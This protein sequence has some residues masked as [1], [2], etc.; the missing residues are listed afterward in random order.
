MK[1]GAGAVLIPF[2]LFCQCAFPAVQASSVSVASQYFFE[3]GLY[4]GQQRSGES[5]ALTPSFSRSWEE[6]R[7]TFDV[8]LFYRWDSVD[9]ERTHFDLRELSY[10]KA[11]E[12]WELR[13]GVC[14]VFWGATESRHLVDVIN[15]TDWVENIRGEDKLGQPMI[16]AA[17]VADAGT[18]DIFYLPYFR[19]RTFPGQQGRFRPSV[20]V[21]ESLV[22]YESSREERH[23]DW[24]LRWSG[25]APFDYGISFFDGTN[26]EPEL[27]PGLDRAGSGVLFPHY[28]QMKQLSMD[29]Q[30]A[31]NSWLWKFEGL[32]RHAS[33]ETFSAAVGGVEYTIGTSLGTDWGLLFEYGQDD[34]IGA[35]YWLKEYF[36][37]G[38]RM[39][40]N[41]FD[42]TE[43][44]VG[45][46]E[47]R[48][49]GGGL[50]SVEAKRT[51]AGN[52]KANFEI[53]D[54]SDVDPASPFY[55]FRNDSYAE[56]RLEYFF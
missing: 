17:W 12:Q 22:T 18:L 8:T 23:S 42:A 2:L 11:W 15:Q 44:L 36:F 34:R 47:D 48:Q 16:N 30:Y 1:T 43:M 51:F 55:A 31:R 28:G 3:P 29:V 26:R 27:R 6:R 50:L 25:T 52:L 7:T 32:R 37:G 14:K 40:L 24:A 46:A 13:L 56:V 19:E 33:F 45:V 21:D 4:P 9:E 10:A 49:Y 20:P 35:A 54:L 41:D 53:L 5:A 39:S 38:V